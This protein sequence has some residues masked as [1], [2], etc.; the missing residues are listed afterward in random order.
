MLIT[1]NPHKYTSVSVFLYDVSDHC[2]IAGVRGTR[3]PKVK[4]CYI[5]KRD[6]KHFSEQ[7]YRHD[8][9][10]ADWSRVSIIPDVELAWSYFADLLMSIID[11]HAPYKRYRVRGRENP[12][13][14]EELANLIHERNYY[15]A[16]ARK[17]NT[18]ALWTTFRCLRNK[19]TALVKK[20]KSSY[21][22][23]LTAENL[24][25]LR[26]FWQTIKS[27]S[28]NNSSSLSTCIVS[29]STTIH[30]RAEMLNCFNKH[31]VSSGF[32]FDKVNTSSSALAPLAVAESPL[33]SEF[34]FRP[35]SVAEVHKALTKLDPKK[36]AGPD[37]IG[38]YFLKLAS[39]FIAEPLTYIYNLT[40]N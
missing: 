8:L 16:K 33:N 2:V 27:L 21:Y 22:L 12:W 13:F 28:Q 24:N 35:F 26:K 20:A 19:C 30:D 11:K 23:A 29:E 15:W 10:F 9:N 32:L 37:N 34:N 3:I 1:N 14:S 38:V 18:V 31:F 25:N 17:S 36:P 40:L 6:T 7:G 4:P 39:D 5:T